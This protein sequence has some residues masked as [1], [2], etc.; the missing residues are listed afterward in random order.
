MLRPRVVTALSVFGAIGACSSSPPA[1]P[2]APS[3]AWQLGGTMPRRALDAGVAALGQVL[4]VAGGFDTG[5]SDGLETTPLVNTLDT[6]DGMW[7]K[8]PD[9]PVQWTDGN[10]AVVGDT[11]YLVGGF[12]GGL[13]GAGGVA[14]GQGFALDPLD[15][16]WRSIPAMPAGLE[17]GASGVVTAPSRIYLLGG[18]SS[19]AALASCLEY[20]TVAGTWSRMP[21]LPALRAHPAAMRMTDGTLIVAGGVAS[22]DASAP[23]SDVWALAPPGTMPQAWTARTPVPVAGRGSCA[24]G[25][26]LGTLICAG[27]EADQLV[28]QDVESY[29]PY[30]DVWTTVPDSMPV[31]RAGTSGAAVGDRLF[32]P[33]GTAT[34]TLDP[35]DTIYIYTPLDTAK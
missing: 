31:P 20:D 33:G 1:K 10:L 26:V 34:P 21:D 27:G 25:V 8:L 3:S 28:R 29:D 35:T 23:S 5:Q 12:A 15:P 4:V 16:A 14:Q 30:L 2:D 11:L 18:A 9:L 17:R 6:T 32:V 7:A 22:L 24:Y 19:T 13:A